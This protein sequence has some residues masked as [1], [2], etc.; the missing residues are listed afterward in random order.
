MGQL[1]AKEDGEGFVYIFLLTR[2]SK[3]LTM[4]LMTM[5][6]RAS[7][8]LPLAASLQE[9]EQ[10]SVGKFNYFVMFRTAHSRSFLV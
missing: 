7:D 8:G 10:V 4:V 3:N 2:N 5:I 6:A 1:L 9:D